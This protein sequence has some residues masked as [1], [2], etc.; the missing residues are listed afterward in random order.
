MMSIGLILVAVIVVGAVLAAVVV[1]FVLL[2]RK[3]GSAS[4]S[5]EL[6][7]L[8]QEVARLNRENDQ[9]REEMEQFTGGPKAAE[10]TDIR[11]K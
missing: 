10:S 8:R 3:S 5:G 7:Y 4:N 2:T 1:G 6:A 11:S 9:L